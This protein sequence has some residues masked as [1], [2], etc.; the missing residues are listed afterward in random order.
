VAAQTSGS[1]GLAG[2]LPKPAEWTMTEAVQRFLP[3]SLF[4][5][6]NGAAESYIGYDF[7][8]LVV[9]QYKTK[10]GPATATIEIYDM[11]SPRNAFGIYGSERYSESRFE[12]IGVQGYLEDGTLNFLAGRYYVKLLCFEGGEATDGHLRRFAAEILKSVKDV[13]GFPAELAAFPREGLVANTEKYIRADVLGFKFLSN[14]FLAAYKSGGQEFEAF[15]IEGR[16]AEN[17]AGM[18]DQ[19][20]ER[21]SKAGGAAPVR[22][23]SGVRLKDPYLANVLIAQTGRFLCGAIKIK[24]GGE[25]A[26]EACVA[27]LLRAL[28]GR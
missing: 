10:D 4:E 5:Y 15:I 23:E 11:G 13:G 1:P 17:A 22:S 21:L 6:I 16:S 18:L 25:A 19:V 8:E 20:V 27:A 14:G 28:S 9:G 12:P 7:R 2:L 3:D 24:D 26:G